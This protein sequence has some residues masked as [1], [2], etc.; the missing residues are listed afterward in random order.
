MENWLALANRVLC[1]RFLREG[2]GEGG[3]VEVR[4]MRVGRSAVRSDVYL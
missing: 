1:H 2:E 3:E 4:Q